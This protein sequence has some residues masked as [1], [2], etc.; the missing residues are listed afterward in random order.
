MC[1]IYCHSGNTVLGRTGY[2]N[3]REMQTN[4]IEGHSLSIVLGLSSGK[5]NFLK[6]FTLY[7]FQISKNIA[8]RHCWPNQLTIG[9][10]KKF[11]W[12]FP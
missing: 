7:F 11:F 6:L 3:K 10:A 2:V 9:L 4:K 1:T 12:L 8:F 5:N